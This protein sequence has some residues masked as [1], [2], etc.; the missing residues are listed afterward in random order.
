MRKA[1][2]LSIAILTG[3]LWMGSISL[4]AQERQTLTGVV[5][6]THCG[7]KHSTGNAGDAGCVKMCVKDNNA[8]YALVAGGK[9]IKLDGMTAELENLAGQTAKLTGQVKG[10]S[11]HV[12][13][14]E[15]SK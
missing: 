15:A 9:L 2:L 14:V 7:L 10:D 13:K 5:S 11:M 12:E 8:S 3:T 1:N 6:N 4:F